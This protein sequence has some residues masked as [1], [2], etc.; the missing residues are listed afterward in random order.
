[1]NRVEK[2]REIRK[3]KRKVAVSF[4]LFMLILLIGTGVADYSVNN[5]MK[6]EKSVN[7]IS[8]HDNSE[9][10]E[11]NIMNF[12]LYFNTTYLDRDYHRFLDFL[13]KIGLSG[14]IPV[15]KSA[16]HKTIVML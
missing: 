7:I 3:I 13:S 14:H 15:K 11:I 16:I 1:L 2:F 10:F 9:Y 4:L 6:N 12:R 5:L 8:F